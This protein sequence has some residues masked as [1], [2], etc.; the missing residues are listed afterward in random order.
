M[1]VPFDPREISHNF[2]PE[3]IQLGE[4]T[5]FRGMPFQRGG[6]ALP[7]QRGAG[8]GSV[9]RSLWR[10]LLPLAKPV[11]QEIGREGAAA[12]ARVLSGVA[13]GK[14]FKETVEKETKEGISNL[15]RT[16]SDRMKGSG[17][18]RRRTIKGPPYVGRAV[19]KKRLTK[20][21]I[22]SFGLF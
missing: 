22:N 8:V 11:A 10:F 4:G 14:N 13:E 19:S 2:I 17:A 21:K 16:A 15:F 1:H 18:R 3:G 6:S 7:R 9:L 12:G 5:P 20:K